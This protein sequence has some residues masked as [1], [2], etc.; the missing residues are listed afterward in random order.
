MV[1]CAAGLRARL[2]GKQTSRPCFCLCAPAHRS[3]LLACPPHPP[4][5]RHRHANGLKLHAKF[6]AWE[7]ESSD[8]ERVEL[9]HDGRLPRKEGASGWLGR[10][11]SAV[12][13]CCSAVCCSERAE[14]PHARPSS[15]CAL[16]FP[17]P[18]PPRAGQDWYRATVTVP[19]QAY[20]LN[21]VFSN[22]D[23][24]FDN[25]GNQVRPRGG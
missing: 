14:L 13:L 18:T 2:P 4:R 10:G 8:G 9:V 7:V 19:E 20:E 22:S 11:R 15:C 1:A 16:T 25:N 21:F 12:L 17:H 23:N 5:S 3:S 24:G 6:N